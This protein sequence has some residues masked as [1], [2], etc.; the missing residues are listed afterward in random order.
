MVRR[1]ILAHSLLSL[2]A[3]AC[4]LFGFAPGKYWVCDH[5]DHGPAML[6]SKCMSEGEADSQVA[7]HKKDNPTHKDHVAALKC[8]L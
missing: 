2:I 7:K 6:E 8:Q 4:L 1:L 5:I 3:S